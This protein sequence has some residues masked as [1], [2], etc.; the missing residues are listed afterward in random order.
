MI[1][2]G[3]KDR[4][5]YNYFDRLMQKDRSRD[6]VTKIQKKMYQIIKVQSTKHGE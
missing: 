4:I 6:H 2:K 3:K 1:R 5:W